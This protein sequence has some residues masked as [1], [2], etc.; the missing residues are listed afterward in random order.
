MGKPE[1]AKIKK[2][3]FICPRCKA[4]FSKGE[5]KKRICAVC[6]F[7]KVYRMVEFERKQPKANV[8]RPKGLQART[9][10]SWKHRQPVEQIRTRRG[11]NEAD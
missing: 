10:V 5:L 7:K 3:K 2:D 1:K 4:Q 9:D 6:G 8:A 11:L